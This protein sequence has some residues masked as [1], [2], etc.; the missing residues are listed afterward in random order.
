LKIVS[1]N[2]NSLNTFPENI[3]QKLNFKISTKQILVNHFNKYFNFILNNNNK[4]IIYNR[5]TYYNYISKHY[6]KMK[7][8]YL[9]NSK[10]Y[11]LKNNQRYNII[12]KNEKLKKK[13][14]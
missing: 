10:Y 5:K 4:T 2:L 9:I 12:I 6:F 13:L 7:K 14:I 8:Q 1:R 11:I 3:K